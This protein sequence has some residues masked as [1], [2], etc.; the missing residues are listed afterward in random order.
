MRLLILGGSGFAGRAVA[1]EAVRRGFDVTVFNRGH[2]DGPAGV[3]TLTGDRD[4]RT[5]LGALQ[6]G[7]WDAVVDTWSGDAEAVQRA[8]GLLRGRAGHYTYV[9][10]R[11]VYDWQR[12]IGVLTERTP[13]TSPAEKG[14]AGD[15][16]RGEIAAASFDGPVLLARAGLILGPGEDVGRLPWWLNR[17]ARGGPT[18]APGPADYP[19]QYID[20]R[21]LAA[22][23]VSA[24]EAGRSG[25]YNVVGPSGHATMGGLLAAGNEVTGGRAD[26]VWVSA[27][28]I[29]EAGI[30]PWEE[31]PIW[32]PPGPDADYIHRGD[33]SKALAAGLTVR[34]PRETVADTWAWLRSLPG[35]PPQRP[36]RRPVG[37]PADAEARV[38]ALAGR[39]R[40]SR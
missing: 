23:L 2:R 24:A 16:L 39:P 22:F 29:A 14:Y 32:L 40:A 28:Q 21:D 27:A 10:T 34:P 1:E 31:L 12:P 17:L 15:K 19:L 4:F 6:T 36:D 35:P 5:G 11:S 38:L 13:L 9:S 20:V 25:P 3:R 7:S 18:V 26:L 37:V 30:R 8:A 33:V